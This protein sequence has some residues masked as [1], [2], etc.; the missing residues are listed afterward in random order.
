MSLSEQTGAGQTTTVYG[1]VLGELRRSLLSGKLRG[2]TRLRQ[3]ELAAQLNVS[4]TPVREA[5]RDLATEGLIEFDPH[6]GSR[7]RSF[8]LAEV[9]ELYQLRLLLEPVMVRRAIGDVT[10][11]QLDRADALR[12]RMEQTEDLLVWTELNREFH[13]TFSEKHNTS[14]L[15]QILTNLRDSAAAY[16]YLSL[17]KSPDRVAESNHEH[18]QL[19]RL[20][21]QADVEGAVELTV[22]HLHT[23]IAT[24]EEAD[25]K[26][27]L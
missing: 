11:A 16:V 5:L 25:E 17:A 15:A 7:V 8:V 21:R 9:Q 3:A 14:R 23:T 10:R 4:I 18:A 24:I 27:L 12:R 2:G 13:A 26:G 6:R 20:Y 22:Q 19:V 1:Y